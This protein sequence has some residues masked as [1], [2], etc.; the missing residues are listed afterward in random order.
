MSNGLY[1]LDAFGLNNVWNR[2]RIEH[3]ALDEPELESR[4]QR[5]DLFADDFFDAESVRLARRVFPR[6]RVHA[7][8]RSDYR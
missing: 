7:W 3:G 8:N 4:H 2:W 6:I 5:H 1:R